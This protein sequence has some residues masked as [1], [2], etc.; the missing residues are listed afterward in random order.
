LVARW[1]KERVG[2]LTDIQQEAWPRIAAGEHV[3]ISAPTASGKTL[4]AFL[5]V[6]HQ[7]IT[8]KWP[9][10]KMSVLYVSPLRALNYDIQ[11]NLLGP[12][13]ELKEIFEEAG[14]SFLDI[15]VL[16]RS[17]DTPQ[18]DRRRMLRHPPEILITTPESLNLL[19]SSK[20]GRSILTHLAMVILDEI[21]AVLGTKRGT[22]LITAVDRLVR[23]SGEF[24]RVA[25]S[26]TIRPLETVA[27]FVGGFKVEG[28]GKN[29]SYAP[30]QVAIIQ[31]RLNRQYDLRIHAPQKLEEEP[32]SSVWDS[33]AGELKK[34]IGRNRSTL[35]FV[36]S[37]QLC[38]L[39]TLKINEGEEEPLAYSHHG[40]LALEIRAE[41]ERRLK[42]GRLRA[43]VA[44]HS[45][46][47]G[48][49]VGALDEVVL[50]QSPFT[51][52][53]AIQRVGRAGHRVGE[54]SRGTFFPTHPKDFLEAAVV[55]P[56][57]LGQDIEAMK[58]VMGPLDV[59][60]QVIV[61]M[62]GVET[63]DIDNLYFHLKASYPYRNLPREQFDL[64]LNMLAGRYAETRVRELKP[65]VSIDRMDHTVAA[66]KGALQVL[67]TS[68]G[69]IPD[70]GYFHLRH[71]ETQA[72]IGDLDEEFVWEAEVGDTFSLG[73]QNWQ[74]TQITHN[75]V[76]VLPAS[77]QAAAAPFWKGEENSRD[78]HFS[79]RIGRFLEE[80]EE[81]LN[82][83]GFAEFLEQKHAMDSIAAR[84][85]MD[86]LKRQKEATGSSL[87]H[88]HHLLV[89]FVKAGPGGS[90]GPQVV[91]H[92]FWGGRVNRPLA[93]AM[94]AAWEARYGHGLQHYVSDDC[95]VLQLPNG[96]RAEELLSLVK[97]SQMESLLRAR[98]ERSG[99]FGARFR[100][101]AG[102][103]LLLPRGRFEERLPLWLSRLRSKKLLDA[104]MDY[105]D[106]PILLEAWHTCLQDEFDLESLKKVLT[107]LEGGAINWT[108]VHTDR[109]SPFA[110]SDWWRQVNQYVYRDDTP[111]ADKV[112]RLGGSLI[113][114][115]LFH[116]G[117]RPKVSQALVEKFE[118][119]RHRLSP[120][121]SPQTSRDL[122][123][124]LVERLVIPE[125]EWEKLL[126]AI[127]LDHT[128][129][130]EDL[131]KD[132]ETKLV[133]FHPPGAGSSLIAAQENFSRLRRSFYSQTKS[134]QAGSLSGASLELKNSEE[135]DR[136][137]TGAE[138]ASLLGEWLR[139]YG[140]RSPDFIVKTLGLASGRVQQALEDLI[141]S[142]KVLR[143]RLVTD[144]EADEVCD[145]ENFEIL[146]RLARSE[147]I[148]SFE[149][150]EIEWL[151]LFLAQ[152]QG[153]ARPGE[154]LEGLYRCLEQLLC[155]PAEAGLWE[156][157][158]FPAR[159]AAYDPSWLDTLLQQ[160]GLQWIGAEGRRVAFCFESDLD[161]LQE[162]G[163]GIRAT[164]ERDQEMGFPARG[165]SG[166]EMS[167]L[168][169]L[170]PDPAGRYDFSALL[171][172]S[173]SGAE[174]LAYRLWE[175]VWRGRVTN[176]SF[177]PLRQAIM[178][179]FNLSALGRARDGPIRKRMGRRGRFARWKEVR[180]FPGNWHLIQGPELADNLLEREERRKDR[181]RLLLDR[182]G[183]LFRELLQKELSALRWTSIFRSLRIMELSGE[184]LAGYF[185]KGI[186]GPQFMSHPA[187]RLLQKK[188]SDEVV[189]WINAADPASLCGVPLDSLR[190]MLPPRASSTHLVYRG[191]KLKMA[192]KRNG[193][194]LHFYVP[195]DDPHLPQYFIA[196]RH[197]LTRKF[198]PLKRIAIET[199]NGENAPQS[200][201]VPS[202]R[203]AFEVLIDYK[204]V[205]LSRKGS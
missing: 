82:Q 103:A 166:A 60:A 192:S 123:D 86:F 46:E 31:S 20:G 80:A 173:K 165:G 162:E 160:E 186:P 161:L 140:P 49:D 84:T 190:G 59:L 52:S 102:R 29:P 194:E 193:E 197:L 16:T 97:S 201:Y 10:G 61:S 41:V 95:L 114:D 79:E 163:E 133:R 112:S 168:A 187:F 26:A 28:T 171:R 181:V 45:L 119:K 130:P 108:E 73:A 65:L 205:N 125:A 126:E 128:L 37:R 158:I 83:E 104:V 159:L 144:G 43:I 96:V 7:L 13:A 14:E 120:G 81:R 4:A 21:H 77:G 3:L 147:A 67:Y 199:I 170:F 99:F 105:E 110:Q 203:G 183:I 156:S 71:Q 172:V 74:V 38:E 11:R 180:Y 177:L 179:K 62:A 57:I 116:P 202:L 136:E 85:L 48:I 93:L 154:G 141:D 134:L 169:G 135:W 78:F 138:G 1:F 195:P 66:R 39:L 51:I 76:L 9:A 107:E 50:V 178:D 30:R 36:N 185:F 127:R 200:P 101:C 113:Q 12:L 92:T 198:Q 64:V 174:D 18:T 63:W 189:Y 55:A 6:I 25:L 153:V 191:K 75:D 87:P 137:E 42:E 131:L 33:I 106:F 44:T 152:Y 184:V 15:Q 32:R 121:Y 146:L 24:Q 118:L 164:G 94:D 8:G 149:P 148:P 98:L 124:W 129:N 139:F 100:Q 72:R 54:V 91:I 196:L 88:R 35:I 143:G 117:L 115:V 22:Y 157:E 150:L 90:A 188:M 47:L 5:W 89:E 175:G 109:P 155:F 111:T 151:P 58:P 122:L 182:Y 17:G 167:G 40:S 176:D 53:S 34:I 70:R 23:L 19:L 69:V 145:R 56:A 204:N 142:Q 2:K 132:L 68:G 27:Q